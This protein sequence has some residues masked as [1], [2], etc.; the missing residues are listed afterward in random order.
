MSVASQ[1]IHRCINEATEYDW[2]KTKDGWETPG[3]DAKI[4]RDG[5]RGKFFLI[6]PSLDMKIS[7][8]RKASYDTAN[9]ALDKVLGK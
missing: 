6:I 4:Q 5:K 2:E 9:R 8:G 3:G 7:L 1:I